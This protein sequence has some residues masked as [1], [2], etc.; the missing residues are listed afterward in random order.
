MVILELVRVSA[1]AFFLIDEISA[2]FSGR[3][4]VE[5]AAKI[6]VSKAKS[7]VVRFIQFSSCAV[8]TVGAANKKGAISASKALSS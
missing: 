4:F 6:K 7:G 2:F 3:V 5:Q 1:G 8:V